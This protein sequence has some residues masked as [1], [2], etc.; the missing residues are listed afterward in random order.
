MQ[1]SVEK[2]LEL[3]PEFHL[4]MRGKNLVGPCPECGHDEF[5]ISL[6]EGHRFGCYR[7][8]KCGFNGNI[9]T[10]LKYLGKWD[11]VQNEKSTTL[12]EKINKTYEAEFT[13]DLEIPNINP[14]I[15]WKRVF[16][17]PYLNERGF[18]AEDYERYPVGI[19]K[20]DPRLKNDYVIFLCYQNNEVKGWVARHKATKQELDKINLIRKGQKKT[21]VPRYK[22]SLSEFAHLCYG[23][24]ELNDK[25]EEL[26]LVEGIFDKV[27]TDRILLLEEQDTVKCNCTYKAGLSPEQLA[28]IK[29]KAPNLKRFVL[30]YDN[31]VVP[32]I[33]DTAA[34][35]KDDYEVLIGFHPT[36]D[37]GEMTES[38]FYDVMR[39]LQ[40][41][42]EFKTFK[43]EVKKI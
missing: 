5:G 42:I 9:V 13:H 6:E 15:G 10:L 20:I 31:D 3:L 25:V 11:E 34:R 40:T 28:L 2:L 39:S 32:I 26:V 35:L 22:N 8:S 38:D 41:P 4:D 17:H 16:D 27:N 29:K 23:I 1:L 21:I 12:P 37:P 43:L 19:T 14:P 24:D 33:N 36:K 18:T 7:K 30:L